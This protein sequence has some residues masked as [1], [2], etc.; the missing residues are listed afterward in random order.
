MNSLTPTYKERHADKYRPGKA[1]FMS[2]GGKT[3]VVRKLSNSDIY[4]S[5]YLNYQCTELFKNFCISL[6]YYTCV[7]VN[8]LTCDNWTFLS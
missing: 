4:Y 1:G 8:R 3:E 2:D 7:C 5:I 6:H